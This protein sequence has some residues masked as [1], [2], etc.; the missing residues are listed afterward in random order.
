MNTSQKPWFDSCCPDCNSHR[1]DDISH[2]IKEQRKKKE[3]MNTLIKKAFK[4][5]MNQL[6]MKSRTR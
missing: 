1:S 3:K 5:P 6:K 2:R 4:T